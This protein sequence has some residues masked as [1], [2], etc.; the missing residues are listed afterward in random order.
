MVEQTEHPIFER[1]APL[2]VEVSG[3]KIFKTF[4]E[5]DKLNYTIDAELTE[6]KEKNQILSQ[7]KVA[8]F[9]GATCVQAQKYDRAISFF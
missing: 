2:L 4:D 1:L 6:P 5:V 9:I 7:V 8:N 3:D